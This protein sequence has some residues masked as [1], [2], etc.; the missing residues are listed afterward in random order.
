MEE[1][2]LSIIIPSFNQGAFIENAILSVLKQEYQN[3]ELV[4]QDGASTDETASVCSRYAAADSRIRFFSEPDKGFADAVNKALAKCSGVLVGIQSS[5][6]F[7]AT[8]E[9]FS[10]LIQI[11]RQH[12]YLNMI[13]GYAV[14]VDPQFRQLMVPFDPQEN[15]FIRPDSVYR[16]RNHFSQGGMFF[17]RERARQVN[18]LDSSVDMVADT[19]FWVRMANYQPVVPNRIFRTS[20]VWACVT[21]HEGQRSGQY[22][23]FYVGRAKMALKHLKDHNIPLD[24]RFKYDHAVTLVEAAYDHCRSNGISTQEVEHLFMEL[25]GKPMVAKKRSLRAMVRFPMFGS[26]SASSNSN[27]TSMTFIKIYPA[28]YHLKWF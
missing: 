13:G 23:R 21:V 8:G 16:L 4:I 17:S 6:D 19:D 12:P 20:H 24:D 5:D 14:L 26:A 10:D 7:Y 28:G 1:V 22:H 27:D 2:K 11:Y 18:G 15:G 25:T 9:V 3:W